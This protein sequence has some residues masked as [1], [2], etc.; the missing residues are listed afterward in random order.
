MKE[1]KIKKKKSLIKKILIKLNRI[2]GFEII[3]QSNYSVVSLDKYGYENL[4]KEGVSSITLPLGKLEIKRPVKSLHIILR[5]CASVKM[6]TQSKNSVFDK[7]KYEYSIRTLN[8]LVKSLNFSKEMLSKIKVKLT[9]VDH[10]SEDNVIQKYNKIL[11]NQFFENEII[12]LEFEKYKSSI[13]NVNEENKTVTENQK[14]NMANIKQSLNIAKKSE[15]L[16]YFVEDDY[17][18][19]TNSIEEMIYTYE[20]LSTLFNDELFLCPIDY[21]YLYME[22][23]KTNILIGNVSH[24]RRVDQTLCTFLTSSKMI[25]KHFNSLITM[26]EK[27]HYPF[28]KPLHEIYKK[29]YCFSPIPSLAAHF[30]NINS[31]YGISP[32]M[33]LDKLWTENE[34]NE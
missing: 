9:I 1:I 34:F 5:S 4:S 15:D 26:C 7:E 19:N 24:W 2:F 31:V 11:N 21:P 27:E 12:N 13:E 14:S 28:E 16:I 30:T 18:H 23:E 32:N 29:E 33:N 6:L 8:S 25:N 10:N 17:L 20:K 22:P 3:D